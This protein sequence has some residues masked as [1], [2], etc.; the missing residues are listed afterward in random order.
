MKLDF[1]VRGHE[2][3]VHVNNYHDLSIPTKFNGEQPNMYNV[4]EAAS[5]A[6]QKDD[7]I[8]DTRRG[9]AC[10]FEHIAMPKDNISVDN[11]VLQG[12]LTK[13]LQQDSNPNGLASVS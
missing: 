12:K 6:Y 2:Y 3:H 5:Q 13:I 7:F 9:G 4:E 10:N 1:K 8:G 11:R